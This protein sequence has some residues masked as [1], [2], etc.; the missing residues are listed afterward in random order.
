MTFH[1]GNAGEGRVKIP[2]EPARLFLVAGPARGDVLLATPL[3]AALRRAWPESVIDVLVYRAQAGI[4]AGNPDV[5]EVLSVSKHPMPER[6]PGAGKF[7]W[8]SAT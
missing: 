4:L 1:P 8:R 2:R 5:N 3:I 7:D 6:F